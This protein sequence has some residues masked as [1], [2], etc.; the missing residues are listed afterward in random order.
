MTLLLSAL[1]FLAATI[2]TA[3][4]HAGASGYIAV[5]ALFGVAPAVMKPT[6]LC[7]NI[8]VATFGTWRLYNAGWIAWRALWPYLIGSIPLAFVGGAVQLP[9]TLY[10]AIVGL[11][12]IFAGTRF[13]LNQR[14][15]TQTPHGPAAAPPL[16]WAILIGAAIGLLSG[17]TGTGGGIYLSPVLLFMGWAG[18]RQSAGITSPFILI[19]SIAGLAGNWVSLASL[20]AELPIYALAAL[21]GALLGMQLAIKWLSPATLQQILGLVLIVAGIKLVLT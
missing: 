8:L 3:V 18:A 4:G 14:E 5:M 10:K 13:L 12:L 2:Y 15:R 6:A 17:L 21:V 16:V 9:G 1:I 20:P 19:N 11:V 7:L